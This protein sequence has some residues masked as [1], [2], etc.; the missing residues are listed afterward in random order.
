MIH[1]TVVQHFYWLILLVLYTRWL[2]VVGNRVEP[3]DIAEC[4]VYVCACHVSVN[5]MVQAGRQ[6]SSTMLKI[7]S[8]TGFSSLII[9][10]VLL[11]A[12]IAGFSSRLFAVIRFESIIHEFDPW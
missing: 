6:K 1:Y 3:A 4:E 7:N 12:W 8:K 11:L 9:F 2:I 10:T 5:R